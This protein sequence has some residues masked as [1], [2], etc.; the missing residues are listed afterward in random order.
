MIQRAQPQGGKRPNQVRGD[1]QR[2]EDAVVGQKA[3]KDLGAEPEAQGDEK[4]SKI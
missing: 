4:K 2:I 3:L 1:V